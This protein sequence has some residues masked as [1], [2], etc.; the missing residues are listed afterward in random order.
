MLISPSLGAPAFVARLLPVTSLKADFLYEQVNDLIEIIHQVGGYCFLVMS[1]NYSVNQS[2]F[3]IFYKNYES[4]GIFSVRHPGENDKLEK[5][6]LSYDPVHLLKNIRKNWV[7]EKM[8]KSKCYDFDNNNIEVLARWGDGIDVYHDENKSLTKNTKLDHQSLWPNNFEKQKVKLVLNVF[9]DKV[10]TRLIQLNHNQTAIFLQRVIRMWKILN[11]KSRDKGRNLKDIDQSP[12][13]KKEDPRLEYLSKIATT[14]KLMDSS[15]KG[16]RV[17]YLTSDT[18]DALCVTLNGLV[19][20][21]ETLLNP[22]FSYVLLGKIQSDR[23]EGEFA[24]YR[25][26]SG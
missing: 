23:I 24:I 26:G 19:D 17:N 22:G 25:Q 12:I 5:L 18:S 16:S 10:A 13:F 21:T 8:Q 11:V 15:P 9:D 20:L 2:M 3:S 7:T 6:Y 1:D 14:F 4:I